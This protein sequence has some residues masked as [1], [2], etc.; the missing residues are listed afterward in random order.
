MSLTLPIFNRNEGA[1]A[2]AEAQVE[3]LIRQQEALRQQV[4]LEIQNALAQQKQARD[5]YK[6]IKE[7]VLPTLNEG[8]QLAEKA[9]Q[10]GGSS[11]LLVLQL[12]SQYLTARARELELMR[13]QRRAQAQI[14][15]SVGY[16]P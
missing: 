12:N 3:Q 1:R 15:R 4:A 7:E 13:D 5:N 2:R 9:F 14:E 8:R 16:Q 10:R 6:V 11:Y